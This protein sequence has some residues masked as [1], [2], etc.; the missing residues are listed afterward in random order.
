M[1]NR[2]IFDRSTVRQMKLH[3]SILIPPKL[4]ALLSLHDLPRSCEI[5]KRRNEHGS[6][7]AAAD[8]TP[9]QSIIDN[10]TH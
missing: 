5:I 3:N 10:H 7:M 9:P 8:I 2:L 1:Q 4:D 6:N